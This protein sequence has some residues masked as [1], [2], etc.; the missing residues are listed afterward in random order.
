M[1]SRATEEA[2]TSSETFARSGKLS[3]DP[4]CG[5]VEGWADGPVIRATGIPYARAARFALPEPVEDWVIPLSATQWAPACPQQPVPFLDEALGG[6][7]GALVQDEDC[8]R[9]S[10]TVPA[11]VAVD[12]A[13]PVMVWIHGGSYVSG[14]GDAPCFDPAALVAEQRVIV[15]SV[16]YR[17]GLFGYL[18]DGA[19]KPANLGLLDQMTAFRWVKRNIAAFGGNPS[20]VTAFGQS[21]GG[22]AI[23]HI[24]ATEAAGSLFRRA[25]IQSP[26]LGIARGRRRMNAAMSRAAASVTANMTTAEVLALEPVVARAG[27][28]FGLR[29][30]MPFGTQY[31]YAPLPAEAEIE[32]AWDAV[33]PRIEVLIGHTAEEARLFLPTISSLKPW[34]GL[35]IIGPLLRRLIVGIVTEAVYARAIRR[36]ARRHVKAGGRAHL[37]TITWAAPGNPFGSAHAIELPVIFANRRAWQNA[38]FLEG[39]AW[40]DLD[41]HGRA[42]RKVWADFARGTNLSEHAD[43]AGVLSSRRVG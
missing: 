43:I 26:P 10:V 22:D 8:Q 18:G 19:G 13:L 12:E 6:A 41:R 32:A 21:A 11:N 36:F 31:G 29:G 7:L 3:F 42:L 38:S 25:I 4:P 24:M 33:A 35:P 30:A 16:T 2:G 1:T 28:R 5:P 14:A 39:A 34:L 17:L 15:V 20:N 27:A 23:A 37:Y 40:S 9:L